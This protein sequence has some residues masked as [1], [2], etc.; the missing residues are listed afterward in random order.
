MTMKL[1]KD[2]TIFRCQCCGFSSPRWSGKCSECG[3]W[4]TLV[5]EKQAAGKPVNRSR[6]TDFSSAVNLLSEVSTRTFVRVLTGIGEFDRMMGGGL[7][8]GS[9]VLLGGPPGIGKSTLMLQ[10]A[11]TLGRR[12]KVLYVSGE[13][14]QEQVK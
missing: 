7:V 14:S 13:E 12:Q 10:I 8:P 5:E 1:I 6:L 3:Q 9:L 4:N 2:K 11:A